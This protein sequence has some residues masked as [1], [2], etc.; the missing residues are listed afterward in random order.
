[1]EPKEATNKPNDRTNEIVTLELESDDNIN[2]TILSLFLVGKVISERTMKFSTLCAIL[3]RAWPIKGEFESHDL[4]KEG[5]Y[6]DI[7]Q[8]NVNLYSPWLRASSSKKFI[9]SPATQHRL[10][11]T[12]ATTDNAKTPR[13]RVENLTIEECKIMVPAASC[14]EVEQKM[15]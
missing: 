3:N 12:G 13:R 7:N 4:A 8:K 10:Q 2:A 9:A 14:N 15:A 1:M 6:K 5:V 11:K